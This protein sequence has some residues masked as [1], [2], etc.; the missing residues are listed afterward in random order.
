MVPLLRAYGLTLR[1]LTSKRLYLKE[2]S[3]NSY[4]L[5]KNATSDWIT[6]KICDSL[7]VTYY[8][9]HADK[10]SELKSGPE[11]IKKFMINSAEHKI[12]S[13]HKC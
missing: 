2:G 4:A 1:Y 13:A 6:S 9:V 12:L 10:L 5:R 3:G 8:P 7:S 11:V